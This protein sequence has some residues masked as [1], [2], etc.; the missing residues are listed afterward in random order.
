VLDQDLF[1]LN[2]ANRNFAEGKGPYSSGNFTGT[3]S[4][5]SALAKVALAAGSVLTLAAL[6]IYFYQAHG[7]DSLIASVQS[8]QATVS[9]C[10]GPGRYQH[11]RFH[12]MANGTPYDQSAYDRLSIFTGGSGL[13]DACAAAT[14]KLL[15]LAGDPARWSIAPLSPITRDELQGGISFPYLA[16]GPTCLLVAGIF[17]LTASTLRRR[18]A[19]QERLGRYGVIFPG[20]LIK[21]EMDDSENS[22]YNIRCKYRFTTNRGTALTGTSSGRRRDIGRKNLPPPG[23]P[24]MVLYVDDDLYEA[25]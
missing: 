8:V 10:E 9:G 13:I 3:V 23:T 24:L 15:Y 22:I 5:M 21:A 25:L 18:Q 4:A 16:A 14:V 2:P 17:G 12:Y 11:I 20:E 1:L 7:R 6:G 19:K